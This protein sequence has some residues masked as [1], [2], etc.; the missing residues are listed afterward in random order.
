L[1]IV[2]ASVKNTGVSAPFTTQ[3]C[4][5]KLVRTGGETRGIA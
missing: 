2:G 3:M 1:A 4:M 5:W